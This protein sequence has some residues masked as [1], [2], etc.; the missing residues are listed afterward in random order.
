MGDPTRMTF[1]CP[2]AH[3]FFTTFFDLV[4]QVMSFS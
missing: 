1:R 4:L 3:N 2:L